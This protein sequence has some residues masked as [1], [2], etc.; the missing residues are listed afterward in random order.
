[1]GVGV[2]EQVITVL[3]P[4]EVSVQ[5]NMNDLP[6][7]ISGQVKELN[8]LGIK[9]ENARDRAESAQT[10]ANKAYII[11]AGFGK[12]KAAIEELQLAV[13][14][15]AKAVV[16][17][18]ETQKTAFNFQT[19]LAEI[20][21]YLFGLGVSNLALNR[22]VVRELE[23]KL[24]GASAEELS[25][26]AKQEALNVIR[27]LKAQEDILI[28]LEQFDNKVKIVH[29]ENVSLRKQL[30]VQIKTDTHHDKELQALAGADKLFADELKT[31]A[32]TDRKHNELLVSLARQEEEHDKALATLK[33]EFSSSL[34]NISQKLSRKLLASY[35]IGGVGALIGVIA[36]LILIT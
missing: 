2:M 31:Q 14:D 11:S 10:S 5:F 33:T 20:T 29:E 36:L 12:K 22:S 32:E 19:Q 21:K 26:L 24:S 28:K 23:L 8:D 16:S 35:A 25:D 30:E 3:N 27:Q 13:Y 4:D 7:I 9:V 6:N 34:A 17:E 18:A 15:L 1:M